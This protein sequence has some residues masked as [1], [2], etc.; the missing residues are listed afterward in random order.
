MR[1]VYIGS[2]IIAA[3]VGYWLI[4]HV[5]ILVGILLA[6]IA[7][8]NTDTSLVFSTNLLRVTEGEAR[9]GDLCETEFLH[10]SYK[11]AAALNW[12]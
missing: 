4:A 11:G 8:D 12:T 6:F 3:C 9:R 5:A 1:F 10:P 7:R 2:P